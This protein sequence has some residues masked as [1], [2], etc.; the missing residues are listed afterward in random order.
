MLTRLFKWLFTDP[1]RP[2]KDPLD[3]SL[4]ES[5]TQWQREDYCPRCKATL[6]HEERM[7]QICNSCGGR[8]KSYTD[9]QTRV[10]RQIW[11][12]ERWVYQ[13]KYSDEFYHIYDVHPPIVVLGKEPGGKFPI[14]KEGK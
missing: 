4:T 10:Y 11:N 3:F 7:A 5:S 2:I 1:N 14:P 13:C 6:R 12:G 9:P 8:W